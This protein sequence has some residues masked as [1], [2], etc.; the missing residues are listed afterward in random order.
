MDDLL[1]MKGVCKGYDEFWLGPV[2]LRVPKGS[3]V[4][5]IGENGAGKTTLMK[6]ALGLVQSLGEV[7]LL[8]DTPAGRDPRQDLGVVLGTIGV[9]GSMR[10]W[11]VE[12]IMAGTYDRW[13]RE[14]FADWRGKFDLP[15]NARFSAL[16]SGGKMI[17]G[18]GVALCHHPRLLILDEPA[19]GL[20]PVARDVLNDI[21]FDF[22]RE[23]D[24]GV[25]ISSHLL[26]DLEKTC[27]YIAFL[28]KGSMK[29]FEEK[30][31]L[32]ERYGILRCSQEE[33]EK[34]PKEAVK[35]L[36]RGAY[37]EEVLIDREQLPGAETGHATIED[38]M[39]MMLREERK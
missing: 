12:R 34:L 11:Q 21:L 38:I 1:M 25:L 37:G 16:S 20:D 32:L 6:A 30:D 19:A 33:R 4:G 14:M 27:D 31:R 36:R 9:P 22:T 18:L 13:D 5:L 7:A 29:F 24:H 8:P 26:S 10:L 2:D 28:H 15:E 23:E 39:V 35:G 17:L 3:I